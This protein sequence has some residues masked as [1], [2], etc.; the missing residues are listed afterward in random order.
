MPP[1]KGTLI[2]ISEYQR[3]KTG[4]IHEG[5]GLCAF[6]TKQGD[7]A[8][9]YALALARLHHV[10]LNIFHFLESPYKM[11]RDIV[12][13]DAERTKTAYI[14]PE[15]LT[16]KDRELRDLFDERVGDYV[17][18]GFRLCEGNHEWE[19]RKCFKKGQYDVLV[20][21][22]SE[23][24]ADFG[25]STTIERFANSFNAPVVLV[26][27][28]APDSFSINDRARRRLPDLMIPDDK[29]KS[30]DVPG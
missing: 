16:Q 12:F 21:G 2:R 20:I 26:G 28:D 10:K 30:I 5:V 9:D 4:G 8:F 1:P 23:K 7:W 3:R 11:R 22:Y 15:F 14:T 24:G 13:V 25:G 6:F 29:W 17:D 18:V 27:P 19:L